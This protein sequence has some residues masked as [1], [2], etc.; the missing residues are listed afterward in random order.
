ME[1]VDI[2]GYEGLYKVNRLG[3][4]LGVKRNKIL[5]NCLDKKT[6]YYKIVIWKNAN[7]KCFKI[8]RLIAIHFIPNPNNLKFIDHI[9]RVRTDNRIENLRWVSRQENNINKLSVINRKGCITEIENKNGTT[10]FRFNYNLN[11]EYGLKNQK[12]KRFK[13]REEAEAFRKQ[14][15]D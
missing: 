11:G 13:S 5:K 10:S 1:F 8:H 15:Y 4:I 3:E 12:S 9:N 6:G 7:A 2:I 14:I